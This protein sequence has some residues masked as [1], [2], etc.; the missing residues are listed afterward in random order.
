MI[1]GYSWYLNTVCL[2]WDAL[3][4]EDYSTV[5]PLPITRKFGFEGIKT[6]CFVSQLGIFSPNLISSEKVHEFFSAIP[7]QYKYLDLNLN[8][9]NKLTTKKLVVSEK[10]H[11]E[12]DLI[13]SYE[14]NQKAYSESLKAKLQESQKNKLSIVKGI[15][16]SDFMSLIA[17]FKHSYC[18]DE[19]QLKLIRMLVSTSLRYRVGELFGVY[20]KFNVLTS[21]AFFL[22]SQ[23]KSILLF[24]I[25]TP[26]GKQENAFQFLIDR[27]IYTYS[28]QYITLN[29]DFS[30]DK[31]SMQLYKDFGAIES[32]FQNVTRHK[33]PFLS[34]FK[35]R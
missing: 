35:K 27:Y 24:A 33:I 29:F 12:I 22:W 6:P 8:K 21:S 23:N 28:N 16:P 10:S 14:K 5:M 11:F 4:E 9:F 26:E 13:K 2:N 1:Y 34:F 15:Q 3:I 31:E 20:N 7:S 18:A 17:A 30:E 32:N 25:T 19:D